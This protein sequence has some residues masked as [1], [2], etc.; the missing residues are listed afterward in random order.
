MKRGDLI[1]HLI[2]H[3]CELLREGR[4]HSIWVNPITEQTNPVPRHTEIDNQTARG[5]CRNLSIPV[6]GRQNR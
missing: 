5:I 6:I 1:R 3:G 4:S 2:D